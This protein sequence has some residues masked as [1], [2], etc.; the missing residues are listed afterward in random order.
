MTLGSLLAQY[1]TK[2]DTDTLTGP[3]VESLILLV[4]MMGA[5]WQCQRTWGSSH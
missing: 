5:A 2:I 1:L 4:A 3:V